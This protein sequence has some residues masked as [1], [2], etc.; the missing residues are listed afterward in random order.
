FGGPS[1]LDT[2]DPKPLAPSGIRGEFASIATN[3]PGIQVTEHLPRLSR[4]ADRYALVRSV[5]HN[6]SSH[7]PGAYYSLTGRQPLIDKVTLNASA[8]DFPHPGSV[9]SYLDRGP[10]AVPPF[11]ALPTMI[12]DGPSPPPGEFEGFLGKTH[13]P[14]WV[15]R[16][17][18]AAD[19]NVEELS[20]PAGIDR[21][22]VAERRDVLRELDARSRL[23]DRFAAVRGMND[24]QARAIDLLTS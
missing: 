19:F 11:V 20:L 13:D 4:L 6:R 16:D 8:T 15:L 2:L 10:K 7:N 3:V 24:Y 17:P 23:A 18:N 22:R 1:H 5:H 14:L 12:A 9:V 21:G